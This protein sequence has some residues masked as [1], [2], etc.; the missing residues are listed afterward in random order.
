MRNYFLALLAMIA[1]VA[2]G[3]ACADRAPASDP[4]SAPTAPAVTTEPTD[5]TVCHRSSFDPDI[6]VSEYS[7]TGYCT[8]GAPLDTV[9][10]GRDPGAR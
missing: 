8:F 3:T 1:L 6:W 2:T 4:H 10:D 9:T 7:V 5:T